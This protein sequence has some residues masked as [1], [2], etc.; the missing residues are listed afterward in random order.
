MRRAVIDDDGVL[1][2]G[3]DA[4]SAGYQPGTV[5]DIVVASSG[6][7]LVRISDDVP[8]ID[9]PFRVPLPR[10]GY[11]LALSGRSR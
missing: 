8:V 2:L 5:V 7:L 4:R 1:D 9:V 3:D 10:R 6:T 11:P